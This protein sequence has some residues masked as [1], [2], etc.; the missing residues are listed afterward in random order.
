MYANSIH[1]IDY[2]RLFCRGKVKNNY[3]REISNSFTK[4]IISKIIFRQVILEFIKA[5]WNYQINGK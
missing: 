2:F 3:F 1:M 4:K 5:F